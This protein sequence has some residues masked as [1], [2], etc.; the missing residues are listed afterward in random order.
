M[1]DDRRRFLHR[2]VRALFLASL[3]FGLASQYAL[4]QADPLPSWND[5]AAKK[6]IM[7]FVARATAQGTSDFV[8]PPERIAVFDNDGTLWT[9]QPVYFQLAFAFDRIKAMASQHP[10]WKTTQPFKGVL[11]KDMKAVA[12]TGEKGLLQIMAVTHAGMTTDEFSK[13]VLDWTATAS[14]A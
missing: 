12:A 8:S 6:S 11:E 10:E 7:D 14:S 5:G 3:L 1:T 4:A 2:C 9:E 13:A